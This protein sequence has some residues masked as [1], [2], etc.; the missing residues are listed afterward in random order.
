MFARPALNMST[1]ACL[2][3]LKMAKPYGEPSFSE[4]STICSGTPFSLMVAAMIGVS[5]KQAAH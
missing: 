4:P 3:A 1:S 2:S 5:S